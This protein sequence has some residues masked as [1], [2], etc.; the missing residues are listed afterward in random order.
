M[1]AGLPE[2][3]EAAEVATQFWRTIEI[4]GISTQHGK[5][6]SILTLGKKHGISA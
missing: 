5:M 4:I 1:I 3:L 6:R 2:A